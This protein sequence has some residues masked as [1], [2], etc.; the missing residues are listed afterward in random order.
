M[1]TR[2]VFWNRLL[3]SAGLIC[4]AMTLLLLPAGVRSVRA[5]DEAEGHVSTAPKHPAREPATSQKRVVAPVTRIDDAEEALR[6]GSA[7]T[8]GQPGVI[9]LNTRG[10]NYGPPQARPGPATDGRESTT[11]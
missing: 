3:S 8:E 11:P 5:D 9:V 1:T 6:R 2:P 7:G 10:Y 4:L